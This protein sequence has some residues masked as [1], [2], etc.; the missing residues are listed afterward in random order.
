MRYL[1]FEMGEYYTANAFRKSDAIELNVA[2]NMLQRKVFAYLFFADTT[3]SW[4]KAEVIFWRNATQLC[5]LPLQVFGGT[6]TTFPLVS[7][8][9]SGSSPTTDSYLYFHG[10]NAITGESASVQLLPNNILIECD[11]VTLD[12]KEAKS[13]TAMRAFLMVQSADAQISIGDPLGRRSG[14]SIPMGPT[15]SRNNPPPPPPTPVIN[16]PPSAP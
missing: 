15:I 13:V 2:A 9:V 8:F 14:A 16:E 11:K 7:A 3:P 5:S 10:A 6:P 12:I 1:D 4:I